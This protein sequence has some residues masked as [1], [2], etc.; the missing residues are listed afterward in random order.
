MSRRGE[1]LTAEDLG[2]AGAMT[3]LLKDAL[4]PNLMQTMAKS[5]VFVHTGPFANIA[6]GNSSIIAD[7]IALKLASGG[8]V[9]T[10]AGFG[11][12][13]GL[14]KFINIKCRASGYPPTAS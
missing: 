6:H 13:C 2:V 9:I 1:P 12:E 10:E 5:P 4:K 8:Y 11:A 3:V 7:A 14:E